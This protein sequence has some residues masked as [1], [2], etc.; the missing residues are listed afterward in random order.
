MGA[1]F[2]AQFALQFLQCEGHDVVVV[3]AG[4]FRVGSNVQPQLVHQF[5]ILHPQAGSVGPESIFADGTVRCTDFKHQARTR[6]RQPF[7]SI[8]GEFSLFIGTELV[9]EST[10]HP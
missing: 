8:T 1:L 4:E 2:G 5:Q 10:D 3:S 6:F 7:P 9:R